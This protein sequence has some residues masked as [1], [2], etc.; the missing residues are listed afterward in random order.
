MSSFEPPED[1][2]IVYEGWNGQQFT[3]TD[4]GDPDNEGDRGVRLADVPHGTQWDELYDAP[5]E[6][7]YNST[8][9]QIGGTFQGIREQMYEF[10]LALNVKATPGTPWRVNDSRFRKALSYKKDSRLRVRVGD[11]PERY[12]TVR[13]KKSAKLKVITDPNRQKYG[14]LLITLV[15]PYPRWMEDDYTDTFTT[16][17]DTSGSGTEMGTLTFS[18]P[19]DTEVWVKYVLQAAPGIV[20]TLPDF[21]FGDDRWEH[22]EDHDD[23]MVVM[24]ALFAGENVL[25]N[26]DEMATEGQVNSSTDTAIYQRM[27]GKEFLYPLQPYMEP[28]EMPVAVKKA[29]IGAG[30][31]V[32][33]PR[34]WTR[35]WGLE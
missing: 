2:R 27:N 1:L 13:M 25:V 15:A 26:T 7:L 23:R 22:A 18:N 31:Q 33:I 6:A 11:N 32:R 34:P 9:F 4:T 12:L 20:W 19:T 35:P 28:T 24:P 30:V 21:S 10:Q 3:I 8:A 14:L 17:L 5:V 29:P 16:T